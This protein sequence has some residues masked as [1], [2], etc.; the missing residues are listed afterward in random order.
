MKV[1]VWIEGHTEPSF[2][3]RLG[4]FLPEPVSSLGSLS[5]CLSTSVTDG[6][7]VRVSEAPAQRMGWQGLDGRDLFHCVALSMRRLNPAQPGVGCRAA[8]TLTPAWLASDPSAAE[9]LRT[10]QVLLTVGSHFC[11]GGECPP[12]AAWERACCSRGPEV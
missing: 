9:T 11:L 3:P 5:L 10:V 8:K 12:V 7:S 2:S 4:P 1:R 6:F